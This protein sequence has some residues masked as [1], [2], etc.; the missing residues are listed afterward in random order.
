M[1]DESSDLGIGALAAYQLGRW[2]VESDQITA[3]QRELVHHIFSGPGLVVDPTDAWISRCDELEADIRAKNKLI[4]EWERYGRAVQGD[5]SN[6]Q[7]ENA[8]LR[9]ANADLKGKLDFVVAAYRRNCRLDDA[10]SVC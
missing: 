5:V 7:A 1:D 6:L 9:A 3:R 10:D 4:A 2:S 8:R